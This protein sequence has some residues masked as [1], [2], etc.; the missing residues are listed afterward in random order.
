MGSSPKIMAQVCSNTLP[1]EV[2]GRRPDSPFPA[3]STWPE[4]AASHAWM[5]AHLAS[6]CA[7]QPRKHQQ[8]DHTWCVETAQHHNLL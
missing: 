2:G 7:Q 5:P 4:L 3:G 1:Q 6:T 8:H